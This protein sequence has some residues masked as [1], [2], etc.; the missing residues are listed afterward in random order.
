MGEI[1]AAQRFGDAVLI[2]HAR[3]DG[4]HRRVRRR[5]ARLVA[6]D[7]DHVVLLTIGGGLFLRLC[8]GRGTKRAGEKKGGSQ[9]ADHREALHGYAL[10]YRRL[11]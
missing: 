7:D 11:V 10:R 5:F 8:G 6:I 2:A 3:A 4:D 1:D 9:G